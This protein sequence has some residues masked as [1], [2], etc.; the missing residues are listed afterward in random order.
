MEINVNLEPSN[1]STIAYFIVFGLGGQLWVSWFQRQM[2]L[3]EENPEL[4]EFRIQKLLKALSNILRTSIFIY[5]LVVGIFSIVGGL[6]YH[7]FVASTKL[8]VQGVGIILIT[9]Q[10]LT[11]LKRW[12]W[13]NKI[14]F[15]LFF[16]A[17][18][19]S[20]IQNIADGTLE[21]LYLVFINIGLIIYYFSRDSRPKIAKQGV[22]LSLMLLGIGFAS[23]GTVRVHTTTDSNS[24][25]GFITGSLLSLGVILSRWSLWGLGFLPQ[26]T[27]VKEY[28]RILW[29]YFFILGGLITLPT[30]VYQGILLIFSGY[31][32]IFG[33]RWFFAGMIGISLS[34]IQTDLSNLSQDI[35]RGVIFTIAGILTVVAG[36]I[37]FLKPEAFSSWSNWA[38]EGTA[39]FASE[40]NKKGQK[41][42]P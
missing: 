13:A 20:G 24:L 33:H 22:S 29:G 27:R 8:I 37:G 5:S 10:H 4:A 3:E 32:L 23:L 6:L 16:F 35:L 38:S 30:D 41:N 34:Y 28:L 7:D 21:G 18:V 14:G 12:K 1:P 15:S 26:P 17:Y 39:S 2:V 19:I 40:N 25:G 36:G 11:P 42:T 9:T 31:A